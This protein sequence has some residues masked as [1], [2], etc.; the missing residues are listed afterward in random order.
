M[1]EKIGEPIPR[2]LW[3]LLELNLKI[4]DEEYQIKGWRAAVFRE[5][6]INGAAMTPDGVHSFIAAN[7]MFKIDSKTVIEF[8]FKQEE[9]GML[10]SR[11]EPSAKTPHKSRLVFV[12]AFHPEMIQYQMI[13]HK[14]EN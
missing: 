4:R 12:S 13:K 1:A 8:L 5:F 3:D 2:E 11:R 7:G 10:T 14:E 9:E 6:L